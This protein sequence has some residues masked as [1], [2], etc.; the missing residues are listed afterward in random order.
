MNKHLVVI[1]FFQL[2]LLSCDSE[3]QPSIRSNFE[4]TKLAL[5]GFFTL[6]SIS[7]VFSQSID[8]TVKIT[9]Y[10]PFKVKNG[11]VKIESQTGGLSYQLSSKDGVLFKAYK[12]GVQAGQSYRLVAQADGF[13]P[14]KTEW[15]SIPKSVQVQ[16][17]RCTSVN[18]SGVKT[19]E[20]SFEISDSGERNFYFIEIGVK[21]G[22]DLRTAVFDVATRNSCYPERTFS[23]T[24]FIGKSVNLQYK[25]WT[26]SQFKGSK[27]MQVADSIVLRFGLIYR[28][29]SHSQTSSNSGGLIPGLNEPAPSYSNVIGGIGYVGAYNL[30]DYVIPV[31]K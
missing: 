3:I 1:A 14:V 7:V 8:P 10:D 12:I 11:S 22:N 4:G 24:C 26:E 23:N 29:A 16:K 28:N 6:D 15:I 13:Q 19:N 31:C 2:W 27:E 21:K 17:L 18:S 20:L 30:K 25:L 9:N 5:Q